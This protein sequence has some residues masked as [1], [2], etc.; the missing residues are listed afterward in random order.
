MGVAVGTN[1]GVGIAVGVA[2]GNGI[3]VAVGSKVDV[4][5]GDGITVGVVAG[6]VWVGVGA[7]GSTKIVKA[8]MLRRST[9]AVAVDGP[10][11][12]VVGNGVHAPSLWC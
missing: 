3:G 4:G 5:A 1:V 9:C 7:A 8:K 2:V 6:T 10:K 11:S 12:T